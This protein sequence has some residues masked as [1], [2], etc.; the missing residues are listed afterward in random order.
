MPRYFFDIS[1]GAQHA[2]DDLGIELTSAEVAR[3]QANAVMPQIV[4]EAPSSDVAE[5]VILTVRDEDGNLV[6]EGRSA[7]RARAHHLL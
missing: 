6:F 2:R 4:S 1:L 7:V 5:G 3:E